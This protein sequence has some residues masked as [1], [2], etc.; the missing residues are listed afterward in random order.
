MT[1]EARSASGLI[2]GDAIAAGESELD[3]PAMQKPLTTR[4]SEGQGL[5]FV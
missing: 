4:A 2:H 1:S 5:E 3:A